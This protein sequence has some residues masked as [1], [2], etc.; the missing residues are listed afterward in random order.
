MP[1]PIEPDLLTATIPS[2]LPLMTEILR[3]DDPV[4]TLAAGGIFSTGLPRA[5]VSAMPVAC[6]LLQMAG[7]RPLAN[8]APIW[9]YRVRIN[10]YGGQ[11]QAGRTGGST[12]HHMALAVIRALHNRGPFFNES[13]IIHQIICT[14][15]PIEMRDTAM[16]GAVLQG[17]Y[18]MAF[19]PLVPFAGGA[20]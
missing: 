8:E 12:S 13:M 20:T 16:N 9:R 19:T 15:G 3:A 5:V 2:P 6:A 7:G 17:V 18:F 4:S 1:V 14:A 11:D 10:C